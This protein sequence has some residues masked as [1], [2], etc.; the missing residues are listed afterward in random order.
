[1]PYPWLAPC[2]TRV[3][4]WFRE[5]IFIYSLIAVENNKKAKHMQ[6]R[7]FL[8]CSGRRNQPWVAVGTTPELSIFTAVGVVGS[9]VQQG[10]TT[11]CS[12][13]SDNCDA[14]GTSNAVMCTVW[15]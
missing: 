2:V 9:S 6:S 3:S 14:G 7:S 5:E 12:A 8:R 10:G 11:S 4:T 15:L 1:M 13:T